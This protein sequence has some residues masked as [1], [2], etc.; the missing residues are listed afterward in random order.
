MLKR[1]KLSPVNLY[2]LNFHAI[3]ASFFHFCTCNMYFTLELTM[4][5]PPLL[6]VLKY[7]KYWSHWLQ[8]FFY[9]L[10]RWPNYILQRWFTLAGFTWVFVKLIDSTQNFSCKCKFDAF[11]GR[12]IPDRFS[13]HHLLKI[14]SPN[15]SQGCQY[16][17]F[18]LS[19]TFHKREEAH[20][21]WS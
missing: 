8:V 6:V 18:Q 14:F 4:V 16:P 2:L 10:M 9:N 19:N 7:L 12:D 5:L 13:F 3:K 15:T 11:I 20:K 21:P 1:N 17:N